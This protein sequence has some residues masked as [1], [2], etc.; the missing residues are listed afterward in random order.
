MCNLSSYIT[1]QA[2]HSTLGKIAEVGQDCQSQTTEGLLRDSV[3]HNQQRPST[4]RVPATGSAEQ[5]R[6]RENTMG[7]LTDGGWGISQGP[8][9]DEVLQAING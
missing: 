7:P 8:A 5:D 2:L 6:H 9:L 1:A 4:H 3:V